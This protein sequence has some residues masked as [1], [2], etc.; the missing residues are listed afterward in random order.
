MGKKKDV[1]LLWQYAVVL[2]DY[3]WFKYLLFLY[4]GVSAAG[5]VCPAYIGSLYVSGDSGNRKAVAVFWQVDLSGNYGLC[6]VDLW[7]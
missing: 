7:L 1:A 6:A 2:R 5:K 3:Y 4:L